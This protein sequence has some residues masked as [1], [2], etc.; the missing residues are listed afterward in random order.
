MRIL[1]FILFMLPVAAFA[2]EP[3]LRGEFKN[4]TTYR[5]QEASGPVCYA[6]VKSTGATDAKGKK[7]KIKG[8][9]QVLLQ[10]T[11]RPAESGNTTVSFV[12][13]QTMKSKSVVSGKTDKGKF[14]LRANGDT[15]WTLKPADDADVAGIVRA[16]NWL[17]VS[18]QDRKGNVIIDN[19]SLAGSTAALQDIA[20]CN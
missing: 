9:G 11:R 8:R 14:T 15:A 6:M 7:L 19:F 2:A 3:E 13:G 12:A 1:F 20:A 10:V 4:W 17:A 5:Y 18:H 16:G